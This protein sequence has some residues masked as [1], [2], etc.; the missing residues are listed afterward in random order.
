MMRTVEA[1]SAIPLF[2]TIAQELVLTD[3]EVESGTGIVRWFATMYGH[4]ATRCI[5]VRQSLLTSTLAKDGGLGWGD[6]RMSGRQARAIL[7]CLAT[8]A[9]EQ[10]RAWRE[11]ALE[12]RLGLD[13]ANPHIQVLRAVSRS[14]IPME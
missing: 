4:S 3:E 7:T 8:I 14:I 11:D 5:A 1:V 13:L 12:R 9:P 6:R 2:Y 10:F